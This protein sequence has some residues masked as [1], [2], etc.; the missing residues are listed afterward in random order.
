MRTSSLL[1]DFNL[2]FQAAEEDRSRFLSCSDQDVETYYTEARALLEEDDKFEIQCFLAVSEL[3]KLRLRISVA[4]RE[5]VEE[6]NRLQVD[7]R[8]FA[9]KEEQT[10]EQLMVD[11]N[12]MKRR[13]KEELE[14]S[15]KQFTRQLAELDSQMRVLRKKEASITQEQSQTHMYEGKLI[16]ALKEAREKYDRLRRRNALEIEGYQSEAAQLRARLAHV[17]KLYKWRQLHNNTAN[18]QSAKL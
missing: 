11:M 1:Q 18:S 3:L 17:E 9:D 12:L 8:Y 2:S 4:Q 16:A 6:L 15:N 14:E 7:K 10:R 13:V 5:E